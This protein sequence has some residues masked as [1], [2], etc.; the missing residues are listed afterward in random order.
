MMRLLD[1]ELKTLQKTSHPHIMTVFEMVRTDDNKIYL[2]QEYLEGGDL[3][4]FIKKRGKVPEAM[5][6][7][8]MR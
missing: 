4:E 7:A 1:S 5:V 3:F 8:M 6:A 2:A